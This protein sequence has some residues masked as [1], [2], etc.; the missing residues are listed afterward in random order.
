MKVALVHDWLTGMRGGERCLEVFCE[1]FPRADLY[2]LLHLPG[3]VSNPIAQRR[4][5]TSFIQRL[6]LAGR[7][8]RYY[9]PL[10]PL[11]I[12]RLDLQGYDLVIS[13]SHCVAK[14]IRAP[15]GAYHLSYVHTPMRYIWDQY[16]AYFGRGNAGLLTRVLMRAIR[17]RLQAWDVASSDRVSRFVAISDHVAHRIRNAYGRDAVVVYPPVNWRSFDVLHKHDGFYLMVTALAPY[18]RVDLAIEAANRLRCRLKIIGTG[19]DEA[20]LTRQAG[21]TV[22][23][24]GWQ[25]DEIVR[26][27]YMQCQ[28]LLFP[29]EEDF[30]IVPLEA[31]ACGKPVIAFA[32]GGALETVMP[33]N[34]RA[35]GEE[36]RDMPLL[37][38]D[39]PTGV[40]F[41]E[42]TVESLIDA[43]QLF[44]RNRPLFDPKAIRAHVEPF[45]RD[46]FKT[47]I[48]DL[49]NQALV[50]HVTRH[51]ETTL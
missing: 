29:G 4:I 5:I 26:Q 28:A 3:T 36:R 47:R 37:P 24:L 49:I 35:E 17:P 13:S 11:A 9:L 39:N 34:P 8:Y 33:V 1:L 18:K 7:R 22:E 32:K 45:D 19:Q 50:G 40:F 44:E 43:I 21:P 20:R 46:H 30:G 38:A 25:A 48:S 23:F 27:Y 15:A 16:D 12:E 6:P 2:T 10:F 42:Q 51:A 41:Y 31:M 14:G